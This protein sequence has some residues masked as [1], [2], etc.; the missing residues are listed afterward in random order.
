MN[1]HIIYKGSIGKE[2]EVTIYNLKSNYKQTIKLNKLWNYIKSDP[3]IRNGKEIKYFDNIEIH[4]CDDNKI[5]TFSKCTKIIRYK[6]NKK[7][8]KVVTK[9]VEFE[10]INVNE[11]I[12]TEDY[13][14]INFDDNY[15]FINKKPEESSYVLIYT[16]NELDEDGNV[17]AYFYNDN[18]IINNDINN[19]ILKSIWNVRR[20]RIYSVEEMCYNDY[21]YDLCV[22]ETQ[23]FFASNI[24]VQ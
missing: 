13:S 11:L 9:L 17:V 22:P 10:C 24:L 5:S 4:T 2:S 8:Y 23:R 12:V 15:N 14:L 7:I 20:F 1:T 19:D 16:E 18:D 3:I 6:T 21:V